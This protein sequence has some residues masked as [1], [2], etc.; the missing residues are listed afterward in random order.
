MV[1]CV[2]EHMPGTGTH[3]KR[4]NWR[5]G[6]AVA[7]RSKR[8]ERIACGK[9]F[10]DEFHQFG[11]IGDVGGNHVKRQ[12]N[13]ERFANIDQVWIGAWVCGQ[14]RL[15]GG[16]ITPRDGGK[17]IAPFYGI[18]HIAGQIRFERRKGTRADDAIR[19]QA[20]GPLERPHRCICAR[21]EDAI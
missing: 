10:I 6:Y 21:A 12:R 20:I 14:Q 2:V 15:H 13:D 7:D 3:F 8:N 5:A 1:G 11:C 4:L 9:A 18:F 17:R 19:L 16:S